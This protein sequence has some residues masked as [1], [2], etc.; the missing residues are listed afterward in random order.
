M[1]E[2][3]RRV[4]VVKVAHD[5]VEGVPARHRPDGETTRVGPETADAFAEQIE[6]Q[7]VVTVS[8]LEESRNSSRPTP[9]AKSRY[10][11]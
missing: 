9:G 5:V 7:A 8:A 2:P 3:D 6:R 4:H 11:P 10:S 1:H